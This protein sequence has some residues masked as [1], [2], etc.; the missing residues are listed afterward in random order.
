[1]AKIIGIVN[2]KG[3]V[4][5]TTTAVNLGAY[6]ASRGK[7][8]LL[9]DLDPQANASSGVGIR[10]EGENSLS[11]YDALMNNAHISEV[12][13]KTSV[14]G[15]DIIPSGP[16]LAGAAIELVSK[17]DREFALYN[18]LHSIRGSYDYI[19]IDSP[20]SL[21]LL[22]VNGLV[23]TEHLLIPIQCEYYALE[24]LG[25][26]MKTVDLIKT[27]ITH[28]IEIMG[29]VLTMYDKRNLLSR[30]VEKEVRRNF[31]GKVFDTIIHRNVELA[32]APS[33]G[34]PIL[35]Y[36]PNSTGARSYDNLTKE[37]IAMERKTEY[38]KF[39]I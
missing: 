25:Q 35:L 1:M 5:K 29:V 30:Q 32:E 19:L 22:T 7:Y 23:A 39:T 2:Q 16:D 38:P 11:L 13:K 3:G 15:Y 20:P 9:I 26:L 12:V 14:F 34:K 10:G 8:V 37:I 6:L 17:A 28:S 4:G 24:G 18:L 36:K 33:H 21:G 27:N 31:P